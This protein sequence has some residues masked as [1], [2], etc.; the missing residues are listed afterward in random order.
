MSEDD[1][2]DEIEPVMDH[3]WHLISDSFSDVRSNPVLMFSANANNLDPDNLSAM[4]VPPFMCPRKAFIQQG[5]HSKTAGIGKTTNTT[6]QLTINNNL[7]PPSLSKLQ[8]LRYPTLYPVQL[9]AHLTTQRP[10][11]DHI[12]TQP[13]VVLPHVTESQL[14][15]PY[16]RAK[17]GSC[18]LKGLLTILG[19]ELLPHNQTSIN[20]YSTWSYSGY[21][22][23]SLSNNSGSEGEVLSHSL[24]VAREGRRGSRTHPNPCS[25]HLSVLNK[26]TKNKHLTTFLMG[27]LTYIL[28]NTNYTEL[29]P[30]HPV[31]WCMSQNEKKRLQEK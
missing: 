6:T 2:M 16:N 26:N 25:T 15:S 21:H 24:L 11:A 4:S 22:T 17:F 27:T 14:L 8:D 29:L 19:R 20:N 30:H 1:F 9:N 23:L 28:D 12:C 3:G 7:W 18:G 13:G 31:T 10:Q 5:Q